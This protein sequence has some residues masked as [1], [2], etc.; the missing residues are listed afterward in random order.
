MRRRTFTLSAAAALAGLHP[1]ASAQ[2]QWPERPV[3][4]ILSQPAGSGPDIL[5]RYLGEQLSRAWKQPVVIDNKPGG[6]NV[7]GAQAAARSP[8]DGYTFYYAT[9]AAMVTN[10]YTFKSLPY[11]PVKD[12][13]PVRL[14]GRSPF[15]IA[16][17]ADF[18]ARSLAEVVARAR[19]APSSVS[20]ATEGPKTFSGMLAD[21]V[22]EMAGVKFNHV[23]YTKA[24]DALQDVIGGRVDLVCLP[25]AALTAYIKGGQVRPLATSTG[26][27][28][29]EMPAVPSL[30]ETFAG[31]EYTGWNALFAPAGTPA[32]VVARVNRDV[33]A[34]LRQPE[35]AQRLLALGS[36]AEPKMGVADF[37][38]FL[39]AERDRWSR[40][41]QTLRIQAE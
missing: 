11:D 19:S 37:D 20:I 31:F 18:P 41:V 22:A 15:V 10:A 24:T 38:A 4:L 17:R 23:P 35:V 29:A 25:D 5:A 28:L 8:A 39:R 14:V 36:I 6:Q 30:S 9:T 27:R 32:D 13:V 16:A 26:Q 3:K 40:L 34:V 12:F 33:E 7:I 21:S 1:Y 2:G